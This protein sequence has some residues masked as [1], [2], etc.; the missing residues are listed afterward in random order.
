MKLLVIDGNSIFNRAFYGIKLLSTKTGQYT[1]AI[2]G[3]LTMLNKILDDTSPDK[4][5][6]A[7]DVK[8]P[9]F[10]HRAYPQYKA[11]R[12]GMPDELAQQ[13]PVLKNLLQLL[14]YKLVEFE[15]FEADDILGTLA[16]HCTDTHNECVI[17][18]GD[19]DSLQLVSDSVNVRIASTKF[20]KTI[21][22]LY[23]PKMIKET[24]GVSPKQ[25]IEIKA[26][27]GDTSDNIPGVPGIGEKGASELIKKF[28]TLDN[29]YKNIDSKDIKDGIRKKLISGKESAY[30]SRMLGTIRIDVPIDTN[31]E[32]YSKSEPNAKAVDLMK[33]LEF[34][35]LIERMGLQSSK[36]PNTALFDENTFSINGNIY[37]LN[38]STEILTLISDQNSKISAYNC[39]HIFSFALKHNI[40]INNITFG[41]ELA[42]YLLDPNETEY[43]PEKLLNTYQSHS[44]VELV[45]TMTKK[46]QEYN[47]MDLL[48]QIEIP[49]A[50]VLAHMEHVGFQVDDEG[51]LKYG[52]MLQKRSETLQHEIHNEVG[53]EFNINSP[54]QLGEALF[55]KM[56]IPASRKTK[57]GY[58]TSADV[59]EGLRYIYPVVEK[60]LSYRSLTKLKS[61]YCDALLKV[62]N[63]DGR[64]H[65]RFN[66]TETRTGRISSADPNLQNIP[67]RTDLGREMR[68]FFK[69]KDGYVLVDADYSQIE[70]RL[71]A[72]I[73]NDKN[74]ID[75]FI[76]EEDIHA[77][78]ASNVFH[79]PLQMVTPI[80]RTRAKA[81]NFGIVYGIGAFSLAKDIG[82]TRR[83]AQ[84]YIDDYFKH[85]S[86]VKKYLENS[87][88]SAK[89]KGFAETMFHRRRYLPELNA[90]N[91]NLR[92]FG[93]RVAKNMPIQGTAADIIK[94]AMVKIQNQLIKHCP[95][96]HIIL[97]IH[98]EVIV[99]TPEMYADT[100][101][102]IVQNEMQSAAKLKI[103]LTVDV[104]IGKT[105]Y[106]AKN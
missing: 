74:M 22:T 78:T 43:S 12:K 33:E 85:Y 11:K 59:L 83:E 103:P 97:Q 48:Q 29:V 42:A 39:K 63:T 30:T 1:N 64:V 102:H 17:A 69:A 27:Q 26:I 61:T 40:N 23:D 79:V 38:D 57:T 81:V 45:E 9:T 76:H 68:K 2:Y 52:E 65:S 89:E 55:E 67:V 7:F 25:L 32:S 99:E 105:W 35:S 80:M 46:I 50:K 21:T 15:G 66:Q 54:K 18:T 13:F 8:A 31:L 19:R 47:Q 41:V 51:I 34:F 5:A 82:V 96:A 44:F 90:S 77:I 37:S 91:F 28:G 70:L 95:E 84:I 14:G 62:V 106:D 94:I 6:I 49:F 72:C 4:I 73:A 93:E 10:R 53:Y 98:D 3:F 86:G 24:Y 71:L 36:L 56:G 58:S 60:I 16:K 92:S 20:G 87:V 104:G 100:V 75:A 101:K 88:Q